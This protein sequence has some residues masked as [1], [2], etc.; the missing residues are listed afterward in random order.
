MG[1]TESEHIVTMC[2]QYL[3]DTADLL[4]E[5]GATGAGVNALVEDADDYRERVVVVAGEEQRGKS[6]LVNALVGAGT[7]IPDSA[8]AALVPMYVLPPSDELQDKQAA[9]GFGKDFEVVALEE[10]AG[11]V[12]QS[13]TPKLVPHRNGELAKAAYIA[14][15]E[16]R[17]GTVTVIDTPGEGSMEVK[18]TR[19]AAVTANNAGVLLFV[20]DAAGQITAPEME[21][22][23][24]AASRDLDVVVVVTKIDKHT[25]Q[26]R[27]VV[28]ENTRLIERH[29]GRSVPV[30]GVST[31]LPSKDYSGIPRLRR[32]TLSLLENYRYHAVERSIRGFLDQLVAQDEAL[33]QRMKDLK[34]GNADYR[35]KLDRLVQQRTELQ[36]TVQYAQF[37]IDGEFFGIANEV[38]AEF[39]ANLEDLKER[40]F[41]VIQGTS[42]R[43][44]RKDSQ[45][46]SVQFSEDLAAIVE[47]AQD[48][49][50]K[51]VKEQVVEPRFGTAFGWARFLEV[52]RAYLVDQPFDST[53]ERKRNDG[54]KPKAFQGNLQRYPVLMF[55]PTALI[56]AGLVDL[57]MFGYSLMRKQKDALFQDMETMIRTAE[58]SGL[59]L[60]KGQVQNAAKRYVY[61]CY[62]RYVAETV[63][64]IDDE[65][66]KLKADAVA[67]RDLRKE[68]FDQAAAQ[69]RRVRAAYGRGE[70]L[71]ADLQR[72]AEAE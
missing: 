25:L 58:R 30:Y 36:A 32:K 28:Q 17:M 42:L 69:C 7:V 53:E 68:R 34:S 9:I 26:W 60:C 3:A 63:S 12:T 46:L 41:E 18:R 44:L 39:T 40:W 65:L 31:L 21:L 10:L 57:G 48:N 38:S 37:E 13:A 64:S 72:T 71:L 29:L 6:S 49:Y 19:L 61:T 51:K 2:S 27:E 16:N 59:V 33:I 55:K 35:E 4:Q 20:T 15:S 47:A 24:A 62:S 1:T 23:K 43:A 11:W 56:V 50:L 54:L 22:L 67:D 5:L 52:N 45:H 8:Q 70:T 14:V 66:K